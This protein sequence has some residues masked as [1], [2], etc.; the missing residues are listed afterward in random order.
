MNRIKQAIDEKIQQLNQAAVIPGWRFKIGAPEGAQAPDF[1][2]SSWDWVK[3]GHNWSSKDGEAWFRATLNPPAQVEGIDL[4]GCRLEVDVFLPIGATVYI[5]G[6]ERYREQSWA[7]TRAI[8]LL[9]EE[10]YTPGQAIALTVR[11][12]QGDGFGFFVS[13]GLHF[14]RLADSIFALDLVKSQFAFTHYLAA[15]DPEKQAVWEQAAAVLD[16]AALSANRW[17]DWQSSVEQ[18]R[19]VLSPFETEAKTYTCN[20]LA[21]SHIDMNWLWPMQETVEVCRRDFSTMD[22]LMERYPEYHFSQSQAAT[23]RFMEQDYPEIFERIRRRVAEG[24]WE[25]TANTWVEGDLNTAAGETL[26]RQIL[27]ARRYIGSK[28]GVQPLVCWEPDTF[29][30]PATYPQLLQKSGIPYYYFC[31]AGKR[32]PLFWW[33][34]P[35]GSRVLGMQDPLGYG[36]TNTPSQIVD[37]MTD[38][39]QRY[40]IRNALYVYGAGDHGGGGTARDIE[41]ARKI[42]AAPLMPRAL[43]GTATHFFQQALAEGPE[44]PV[45]KAE[46]NTIFEGCYTSHA[47]IKRMNRQGEN[48]LLNAEA[49]AALSAALTGCDLPQSDLAEAWRT[50]CFHQFHDILCGCAIGVT[51]REAKERFEQVFQAGREI[52]D[53]AIG[54]LAAGL[55]TSGGDAQ[56]DGARVVIFNPLAW[57]R[58]DVVRVPLKQ[59][60]GQAPAALTDETGRRLPVQVCGDDL[61]FVAEE[62]PAMGARVYRPTAGLAAEAAPI[63][64]EEGQNILDNGLLRL[65]VHP[66]SGAVEQLTDLASDRELATPP[67]GWGPEAKVNA[68]MLNRMQILW[69]QPHTMSAWNIGDITRVD[70]LISG[71][72]VKVTELGPV[73]GVIEVRR[74]F[75]NSSLVQRVILYRQMRRI[76]FETQVDWHERGS[77]HQ[78][79]PM[80]RTTFTP[81]LGHTQAAFEIAFAGLERPADGREVPA[82]RWSDLTQP[83]SPS[84]GAFGLSLLNDCKYG[85][86]TQGNTMGLTLVRASYEPD[87]NPDEGLHQF[88]YSLYPHDGDWKQA[89]T[90]QRAAELNQPVFVSVTHAH[91]GILQPGLP[92][93]RTGAENAIVSAVKLAE[94]QPAEGRALIVRVYE[95]HGKA[96]QTALLPA[97]PVARAEEVNPVEE[98]IGELPVELGAVPLALNPH[99]IKTVKLYM[100]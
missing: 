89:G 36:G 48:S 86:Q 19:A 26:V 81:Y 41:A 40:G 79:A 92:W 59:F 100:K 85:H 56:P 82:L 45:V 94:D 65:K 53:R 44:L 78:D 39:N 75:L 3:L 95:A 98:S 57:E 54:A 15:Q 69:E 83:E 87:N 11:C 97:W 64:S 35:D 8:P 21:H 27:H 37:C 90:I 67:G 10:H 66:D 76:D 52:S 74:S 72:E 22:R 33:E 50:L 32:H 73:R 71:A 38:F 84:E 30:H 24:R 1:N 49:A 46:L 18:A 51:Y 91:P 23:Y 5:N 12:N 47:D 20:L 14:S 96:V 9:L 43:P 25:I 17:D 77:A 58:T 31:R 68:G 34:G 61:V 2:D 28:F 63:R 4:T 42:D 55:D 7:D 80:L 13:A 60:G 62:L 16:F 88:T 6:V 93:L 99:E 70:S 29:G